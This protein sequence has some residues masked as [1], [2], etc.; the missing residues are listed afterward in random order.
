MPDLLAE[1]LAAVGEELTDRL[2]LIRLDPAYRAAVRRR[3]HAGRAH[4]RRGHDRCGRGVRR[5]RRGG[6]VP[7]AAG[8]ADRALPARV[9]PVHRGQL[10]FAAVPGHAEPGPAGRA[11]GVPPPGAG[12]RPVHPRRAAA[13]GVLVPVA[14][15]GGVA[16]PCAGRLRGHRLH[17]HRGRGVLP[18]RRD[19]GGA[20]RAGRRG[21]C[22]PGSKL[23]YGAAVTAL[24]R[25]GDRVT[26]VR[27]ADGMRVPC[28]AVVLATELDTAYQLLGPASAAAGARCARRRPRW[29]CTSGTG[30]TWP[31]TAHHTISFGEAWQQTFTRDH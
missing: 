14:V 12:H 3:Q 10:R 21:R 16:Q 24:E 28:D 2:D 9:R 5:A 11:G 27:T 31:E 29:C 18:P 4:R 8:L 6:R 26:A 13:P 7:A 20:G 17:G 23:H 22:R 1:P 19:A 15:R 25:S 30:R